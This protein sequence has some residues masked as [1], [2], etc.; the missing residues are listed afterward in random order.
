MYDKWQ[1]Q[2]T[3]IHLLQVTKTKEFKIKKIKKREREK[4]RSLSFPESMKSANKA[5]SLL[6]AVAPNGEESWRKNVT[7]KLEEKNRAKKKVT[8]SPTNF[9]TRRKDIARHTVARDHNNLLN[10]EGRRSGGILQT[11]RRAS[12]VTRRR[13]ASAGGSSEHLRAHRWR[14]TP[15]LRY[16]WSGEPQRAACSA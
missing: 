15:P 11:K 1:S 4:Q 10:N 9:P 13:L 3:I 2:V 8:E 12:A 7:K 14:N 6:S 5:I 16:K